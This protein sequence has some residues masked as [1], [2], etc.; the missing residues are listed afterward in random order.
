MRGCSTGA[1]FPRVPSL[2]MADEEPTEP[3]NQWRKKGRRFC[4]ICTRP[5]PK[6]NTRFCSRRCAKR[7]SG[8]RS[9]AE[10]GTQ[11]WKEM[12]Q[13][14]RDRVA[15]EDSGFVE[16]PPG[17]LRWEPSRKF[18]AKPLLAA[19]AHD[20]RVFVD[21]GWP[22]QL[23]A[24]RVQLKDVKEWF[25]ERDEGKRKKWSYQK[26]ARMQTQWE[27][28]EQLRLANEMG[29][30]SPLA[31]QCLGDFEMFRRE[32]FTDKA[33]K[34]YTHAAHHR[35]WTEA[36]MSG[37][38]DGGQ[39]MV[40]APPRHGKTELL[41]HLCLWL[42]LRDPNIRIIWIGGNNDVAK[43]SLGAVQDELVYNEKLREHF[44]MEG[45]D[46]KP[47][48]SS[49]KEWQK[50]RFTI[51]T[52]TKSGIK[53]PTMVSIGRGGR[54]LSRDADIIIGDDIVDHDSTVNQSSRDDTLRW[55]T[56]QVISRKEAHT[57]VFLIGSRQHHDDL[58]G[59]L[60]GNGMW[61]CLVES[62]HD[63]GCSLADHE[64]MD[65]EHTPQKC[66]ICK[67]HKKCVLWDKRPFYFLQQQRIT[68]GND[69]LF[70]MVYNNVTRPPGSLYLTWDDIERTYDDRDVGELPG[71]REEL[72]LIAGM[73]PSTSGDQAS[74]LW[75]YDVTT[76]ERWMVDIDVTKGGGL[77]G[78][79]TVIKRWWRKYQVGWWVIER[80]NYQGAVVQDSEIR[81]F[82]A[83]HGI[84]LTPTYTT[85]KN[86]HDPAMG[87]TALMETFKADPPVTHLPAG[88]DAA[89]A[90]SRRYGKQLVNFD[91]IIDGRRKKR[92]GSD[93]IVMASWFPELK[94]RP[95]Y[96][97]RRRNSVD[98]SPFRSS[99][100][101][102]MGDQ[103]QSIG[104]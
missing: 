51:N 48:R 47:E 64:T 99:Y 4:E 34:P 23:A 25:E 35:R 86:K 93:D 1:A 5:I 18:A 54:F 56:T 79:R 96:V 73:D 58:Y 12:L 13:R 19:P 90:L 31:H 44:L 17:K 92:P 82:C 41:I 68:Y 2:V 55:W 84:R 81:D 15:R 33:G 72:L 71:H 75:A 21:A 46:F 57:A 45:Q 77:P 38:T 39:V 65:P 66:D 52:R 36:A 61:N 7:F 42:M 104:V 95:L 91:G 11:E 67:A 22:E 63:T 53:S 80:N 70:N 14:V 94:F 83:R 103:Y 3:R 26:L 100:G 89:R 97:E 74:F 28:T 85:G 69:D 87:V 40:L 59:S 101:P 37:L 62:A 8:M 29:S 78:A 20:Y 43:Q 102:T 98:T 30:L 6:A 9:H 49:G 88:T 76:K 10:P 50:D 32:F 24:G 16:M 27:R 60:L